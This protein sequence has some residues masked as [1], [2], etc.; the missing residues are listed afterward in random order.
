MPGRG[1]GSPERREHNCGAAGEEAPGEGGQRGG[2]EA[3]TG[4]LPSRNT[5]VTSCTGLHAGSPQLL[6]L[7]CKVVFACAFL[8]RRC[9]SHQ[10]VQEVPDA[11]R[12]DRTM[13]G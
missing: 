10:I 2:S 1:L 5:P 6:Q 3:G 9:R 4:A 8:G 13:P 12:G 11:G 7:N